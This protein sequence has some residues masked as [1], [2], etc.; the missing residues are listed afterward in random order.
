[1]LGIFDVSVR[2]KYSER[3][4]EVFARLD[5]EIKKSLVREYITFHR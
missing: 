5:R 3:E 2:P 4:D 1:M